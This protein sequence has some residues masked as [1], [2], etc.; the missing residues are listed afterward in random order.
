MTETAGLLRILVSPMP[1]KKEHVSSGH[2]LSVL[3][4]TERRGDRSAEDVVFLTFNFDPAYF[5]T[6][7]LPLCQNTG[8]ATT[9]VADA[10]IWNPDPRTLVAAG[11]AYHLSLAAVPGAFHPK[12]MLISGPERVDIVIGSGNLTQGGWQYNDEI[13]TSISI[14]DGVCP[15]ISEDISQWLELLRTTLIMDPLAK[16]ALLRV[17]QR[18]DGFV[19]SFAVVD[20]GHVFFHNMTTPIGDQLPSESVANLRMYA[21]F[22]DDRCAAIG[23]LVEHFSPQLVEL[24]V[25][26]GLTVI[27]SVTLAKTIAAYKNPWH[28]RAVAENSSER[29]RYRHGKLIEWQTGNETRTLTGSPNL[30]IAALYKTAKQGNCE[31]AISSPVA[32]SL[33]PVG[34][35]ILVDE[36]P[37]FK[38]TSVSTTADGD[39]S[40]P[41]ILSAVITREGIAL[42]LSKPSSSGT[43]IEVSSRMDSPD[44]WDGAGELTAGSTDQYVKFSAEAGS[45]IRLSKLAADGSTS[46]GASFPLSD[47]ALVLRRWDNVAKLIGARVDRANLWGSDLTMLKYLHK[48]LL[49]LAR[50]MS[51]TRPPRIVGDTPQ[52]S[53]VNQKRISDTDIDPWK[54]NESAAEKMS[55]QLRSFAFGLPVIVDSREPEAPH[56]V[57]KPDVTGGEIDDGEDVTEDVTEEI[58]QL[59]NDKTGQRSHEYDSATIRDRRRKWCRTIVRALPKMPLPAQLAA[60]RIVLYLYCAENWDIE[61]DD[62]GLTVIHNILCE[63]DIDEGSTSQKSSAA[64]LVAVALTVMRDRIAFTSHTEITE[65]YK[66]LA[67][68]YEPFLGMSDANRIS[69]YCEHLTNQYGSPLDPDVV[70]GT[71]NGILKNDAIANIVQGLKQA[72]WNVERIGD[73][74]IRL[75]GSFSQPGGVVTRALKMVDR[76]AHVVIRAETSTGAYA[77][78]AWSKPDL[79]IIEPG[80]HGQRWRHWVL[81]GLIDAAS[82]A[83]QKDVDATV[84]PSPEANGPQM[85]PISAGLSLLAELG[86]EWEDN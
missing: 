73:H 18:I 80:K 49:E 58:E 10:N 70:R 82:F 20:T 6:R 21:P 23:K 79:F 83:R 17:I 29:V 39:L 9:V 37:T 66:S 65:D 54:W 55:N 12:V 30:S 47:P 3:L 71:I 43:S 60:L 24:A 35:E 57:D 41:I 2:P 72:E 7:L 44:N 14:A 75:T 56:W 34:T 45:R 13:F 1:N 31:A 51:V 28:L 84:L 40:I 86:F 63:I 76:D 8:G 74:V 48:E 42:L 27:N 53:R 64:S 16:D 61:D 78:A 68:Y 46:Y 67:E 32:A 77:V 19:Q 5:E 81:D 38:I 11:R 62:D 85:Q 52:S 59:Q 33:Y 26:P 4:E 15:S 36:V 50:Q 22:H 25:Q 69:D